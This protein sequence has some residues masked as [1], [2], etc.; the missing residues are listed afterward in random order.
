MKYKESHSTINTTRWH[1]NHDDDSSRCWQSHWAKQKRKRIRDS[2]V[3]LFKIIAFNIIARPYTVSSDKGRD[4]S[5][6]DESAACSSAPCWWSVSTTTTSGILFACGWSCWSLLP[7]LSRWRW[8]SSFLPA[9]WQRCWLHA[10]KKSCLLMW[11]IY[12]IYMTC[13]LLRQPCSS[14]CIMDRLTLM[15]MTLCMHTHIKPNET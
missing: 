9:E 14:C 5:E 2:A 12:F 7:V 3:P 11:L 10:R 8:C 1:R 6:E 13:M 4:S 15:M